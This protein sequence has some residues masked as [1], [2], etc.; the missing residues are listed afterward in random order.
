MTGSP[1]SSSATPD[2]NAAA[3]GT[4]MSR[5]WKVCEV[6][7]RCSSALVRAI[8]RRAPP[9]ASAAQPSRPLSGP[10]STLSPAS[11]ATGRLVV[12]TPGSTTP[13]CTPAGRYGR[14]CAITTAPRRMSPGGIA[15]ETSMRRTSGT[16]AAATPWHTATKPS[17]SP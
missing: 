5:P 16:R 9:S 13:T 7:W 17:S 10:T 8:A 1:A 14:V 4:K 6:G 2:R 15:C 11:I 12:P 3:T